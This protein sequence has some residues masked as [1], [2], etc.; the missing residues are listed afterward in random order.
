[1]KLHVGGRSCCTRHWSREA[2]KRAT[3]PCLLEVCTDERRDGP[4]RSDAPYRPTGP[5][6]SQGEGGGTRDEMHGRVPDDSS[7]SRAGV[8]RPL[9]GARRGGGPTCCW[10]RRGRSWGSSGTLCCTSLTSCRTCRFS[11]CLCP[12]WG[13]SWW[14]S[15]RSTTLRRPSR[16]SKCPSC[17]LT[18]FHSVLPFAVRRRRSSWW[19]CRRIQ[20]TWLWFSPRRS[21]R[22]ESFVVFSQDIV[23]QRLGPQIVDNPVPQ[24]RRGGGDGTMRP[25]KQRVVDRSCTCV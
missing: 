15:R 11:M 22:G 14:N 25:T 10:S 3:P 16:L 5:E 18:V 20:C 2:A 21:I 4:G 9:R 7:S 6:N 8:P 12:S 19:K 23:Q 17:L 24:G 1:M 13:R